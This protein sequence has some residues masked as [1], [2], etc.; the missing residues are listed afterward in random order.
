MK[1]IDIRIQ[2]AI[3]KYDAALD[4]VQAWR[5]KN[6]DLVDAWK[7]DTDTMLSNIAVERMAEIREQYGLLRLLNPEWWFWFRRSP[8]ACF[9]GLHKWDDPQGATRTCYRCNKTQVI[10]HL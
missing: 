2:E 6:P 8:S 4:R 9:A 5:D 10:S 3:E 7:D 1:P